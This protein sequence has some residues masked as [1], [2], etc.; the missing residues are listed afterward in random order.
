MAKP[1]PTY[2]VLLNGDARLARCAVSPVGGRAH[3]YVDVT[4]NGNTILLA[5]EY[6]YGGIIEDTRLRAEAMA[7]SFLRNAGRYAFHYQAYFSV[8]DAN[9]D[10]QVPPEDHYQQPE[11]QLNLADIDNGSLRAEPYI[12]FNTPS[13]V[14]NDVRG[15]AVFQVADH[16]LM[17]EIIARHN[18]RY[19]DRHDQINVD[20]HGFDFFR[21]INMTETR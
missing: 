2:D 11:P 16:D 1:I 4:H 15:D 7:R 20:N 13:L 3:A 6:A 18:Q 17:R 5:L 14:L 8:F 21:S 19:P 9:R 10:R 12:Q